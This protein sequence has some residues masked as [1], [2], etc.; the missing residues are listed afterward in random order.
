M[1]QLLFLIVLIP[2]VS[3]A[4]VSDKLIYEARE[5]IKQKVEMLPDPQIMALDNIKVEIPSI[6][7]ISEEK[8]VYLIHANQLTQFHKT[9][10]TIK[11]LIEDNQDSCHMFKEVEKVKHDLK[12]E[13]K[14]I[15]S[16]HF[17]FSR[18]FYDNTD[19]KLKSSRVDVLIRDF[20]IDERTSANFYNPQNWESAMDSLRWIDE[21]TNHFIITAEKNNHSIILSI[22]HPKFLKQ[23]YQQKHVTGIVDGV[24]V[25]EVMHIN[26][27]F[28]GYNNQLGEM[29]LVRFENTHLQMAWEVGYGYDIK[30]FNSSKL[31]TL[32][33]RPAVFVGMMSGQNLSVYTKPGEYWDYDDGVDKHQIQGMLLSGQVRLNYRIQNFNLFIDGKYSKASLKHGFFDGTAEYDLSYK[34]ITFGIGYTFNP[35]KKK[36]R[37]PQ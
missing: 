15:F 5:K 26:E 13:N 34:A 18:T 28:D 17:G 36:R 22:F 16:F 21:P 14:W 29:Y 24:A 23:Q 3:M 6:N 1:K 20:E 4:Q 30:L 2:V 7:S 25:D 35:R 8:C 19:M 32:S 27:P 9:S 10:D 11:S 33:I 37:V 31:G 12:Q